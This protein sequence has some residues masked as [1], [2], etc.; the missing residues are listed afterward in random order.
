[1]ERFFRCEEAYSE[2]KENNWIEMSG[3]EFYAFV[4]DPKNKERYFIKFDD[5]LIIECSFEQYKTFKSE[6]R[7]CRY[8]REHE[9]CSL[10]YSINTVGI[11]GELNGEAIIYD[12]NANVEDSVLQ[13]LDIEH[14]QNALK[15]L[16]P[17]EFHLIS[18]MYL[19]EKNK[20]E[21]EMAALYGISPNGL[22][23]KKIK[24][25]E[26]LKFLVGKS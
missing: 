12:I 3:R 6:N 25:L 24:I 15:Q 14:L 11:Y 8:L 2:T 9:P 21:R 5:D 20:T 23:K 19:S 1:M 7:H 10:L 17:E 13:K 18:S 16:S 4:N 26:K 22:H